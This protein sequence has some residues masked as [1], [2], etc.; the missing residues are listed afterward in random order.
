MVNIRCERIDWNTSTVN[1]IDTKGRHPRVC[2]ITGGISKQSWN[3]CR[4]KETGYV[5]ENPKTR[6]LYSSLKTLFKTH[7]K[8][9]A[10]GDCIRTS[11]SMW[12]TRIYWKP[13]G[14]CG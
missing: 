8:G 11:C 7:V 2:I 3:L 9:R 12:H 6:K 5:F 14:I 4:R 13:R 1:L 10:S